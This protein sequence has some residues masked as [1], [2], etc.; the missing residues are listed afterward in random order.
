MSIS[1]TRYV[2]I[3]S[4]VGAAA[5]VSTRELIG[6]FYSENVLIPTGTVLEFE[7]ADDV[8]DYFGADSEEYDRAAFYF[9]WISKNI[10]AP[11]KIS[12]YRWPNADTF[13][14]I[15]GKPATYAIGNFTS[16]TTGDLTLVLGGFTH[17][18]TGIDLSGAGSL[19][20]VATL[21][22]TAIRA[23]SAGGVAWTSATVVYDSTR[24]SFNLTSGLDG[25]DVVSV[26]AGSITDVAGPLGWLTGAIYSDGANAQTVTEVLS[27]SA[28]ISNNFGSF[29]FIP[30]LT[31]DQIVDAATWNKTQDNMFVYSVPVTATCASSISAAVIDIGGATVTLSEESD[32]YPEQVPMMIEAATDYTR[33]NSTQNYMF[34]IFNL[35]PS[36]TTNEDANTY[37]ALRV[38]Y[39]GQTQSA[40]QLIK[41]YQRG[42]MMGLPV[43]PQDQ[44]VY[45]NEI[46]LKDA[47]GAALMTLLLAL[48]KV[49]ANSMGRSQVLA[50]M[51]GIIDQA[52]FNGTI[53]VGKP[54]TTAQ[55]LYISNAT[56]SESAWQQVQN[57]GYW[58]DA[59]PTP[60]VDSGVTKY[61]IVYTLIYSKDDI[62]RKIDGS[63][64]L[65]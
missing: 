40:G 48:S 38:N 10:T 53:S 15:F 1:M 49:S 23:Y 47:M 19:S 60:Y 63:D 39:Y 3:V 21:I 28:N 14:Q 41:F 8:L 4:G 55:K 16:I 13:S 45:I 22:Q 9:G 17:H 11:Q 34:Q 54:L 29:A 33:R 31:Q 7:S 61:K 43:D 58:F 56:G 44:N 35:T 2:D 18:L 46:W 51:Q 37:D 36:V 25:D 57:I 27:A 59:V 5:G 32:E 24:K 50:T 6:R 64:I 20:A 30:T 65:I 26:T 12:F 52:L 42:L 62:I